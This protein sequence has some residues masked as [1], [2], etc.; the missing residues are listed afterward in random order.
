[1]TQRHR[2]FAGSLPTIGGTNRHGI[3][4]CVVCTIGRRSPQ[5]GKEG[6]E[7][8]L[9]L[10]LL[11]PTEIKLVVIRR[12]MPKTNR[13]TCRVSMKIASSPVTCGLAILHR[14]GDPGGD[15]LRVR[16]GTTPSPCFGVGTGPSR[17]N[18]FRL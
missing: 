7:Y 5:T 14:H 11:K 1:V 10:P 9:P 13:T 17:I 12:K 3:A 8:L 6:G 16:A 4:E 18:S 2:I 15:R